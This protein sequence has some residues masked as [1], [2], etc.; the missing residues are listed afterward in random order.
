MVKVIAPSALH[1]SDVGGIVLGVSGDVAVAEAFDRV[2]SVVDDATGALVQE[3]VPDGHEVIIGMTEDPSFGPLLAFGL[4]GVFVELI[5]DIAFRI[6]P[7]TDIDADEMIG[8]VRA[9]RLLEGYRGEAP[10]DVGA[11]R[12][13][14]LRVSAMI[15][16]LPEIA[17]MDLNPV[18]VLPPGRGLRVVDLRIRVRQVPKRWLPSRKDIPASERVG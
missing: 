3:Y 2:T 10:G 13:A 8:E 14:L 15:D 5:G 4:G 7:L 9:A 11:L 12:E 17:E 6:H 18:K 1:K 16:D